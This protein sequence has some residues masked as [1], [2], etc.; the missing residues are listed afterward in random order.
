MNVF[1]WTTEYELYV[2]SDDDVNQARKRLK[3]MIGKNDRVVNE[4]EDKRYGYRFDELSYQ[5]NY[6]IKPRQQ[7]KI[8]HI[9]E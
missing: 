5:P 4:G 1:I 3:Q 2:I 7:T 6:I 8:D 9:N